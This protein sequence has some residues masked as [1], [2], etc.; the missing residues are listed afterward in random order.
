MGLTIAAIV[1]AYNESRLL[2]A[3]LYS[4]R[5]Q[6][7]PPDDILVIDNASTDPTGAVALREV[8]D[9]YGQTG[10]FDVIAITDHI[11]M[12]RDLLAL[13]RGS[14]NAVGRTVGEDLALDA[15]AGLD[16]QHAVEAVGVPVAGV[17]EPDAPVPH[18][19]RALIDGG[20]IVGD[21]DRVL[22]L[23]PEDGGALP[24]GIAAIDEDP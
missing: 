7:R 3:C 8:V 21:L 16:R 24:A 13:L 20:H 19:H 6:T 14:V 2:P 1:C 11:L 17:L 9:L 5:A 22:Q 23:V 18:G 12:K 15:A 10:R 4:L